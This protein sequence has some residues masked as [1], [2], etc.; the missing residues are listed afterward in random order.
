MAKVSRWEQARD[1]FVRAVGKGGSE[2]LNTEHIGQMIITE[3]DGAGKSVNYANIISVWKAL[4]E[5][6]TLAE[7]IS[8]EVRQPIYKN[9]KR[10]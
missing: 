1:K 4:F 7:I 8:E 10:K 3:L 9:K 2:P 6:G 5:N